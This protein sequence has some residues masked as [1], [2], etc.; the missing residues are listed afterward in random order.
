MANT[1]VLTVVPRPLVTFANATAGPKLPGSRRDAVSLIVRAIVTPLAS[2]VPTA[3]LAESHDGVLIE[4]LT[5]P[6][7]ELRRYAVYGGTMY[8]NLSRNRTYTGNVIYSPSA[9]LQFSL[10]YRHLESSPVVGLPAASKLVGCPACGHRVRVVCAELRNDRH[11]RLP[12]DRTRR[13]RGPNGP[14]ARTR[15]VLAATGVVAIAAGG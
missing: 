1:E 14:R 9:Y 2:V 8:Q 12:P 13:R 15:A 5:V 7:D 3:G 4:Y 10:E 6:A 11:R